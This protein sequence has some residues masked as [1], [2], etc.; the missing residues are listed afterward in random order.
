MLT[1]M[2]RSGLSSWS[3]SSRKSKGSPT[4]ASYWKSLN[5]NVRSW[6]LPIIKKASAWL[7]SI[8]MDYNASIHFHSFKLWR[9]FR[10][11][12]GTL[13]I[14]TKLVARRSLSCTSDYTKNSTHKRDF[15]CKASRVINQ[16]DGDL[17]IQ[18]DA[19]KTRAQ[20]QKGWVSITPNLRSTFFEQTISS[21]F[22][23]PECNHYASPAATG[24]MMLMPFA[25]VAAAASELSAV[26]AN[27][28][29]WV[30]PLTASATPW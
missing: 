14:N 26:S 23:L 3:S 30:V 22:A 25:S 27:V 21:R 9:T 1:S 8:A 28:P 7:K 6:P 2:Q 15:A 4:A 19:P 16:V 24:E 17:K 18:T 12:M 11:C 20:K 13:R 5:L 10:Y 29:P